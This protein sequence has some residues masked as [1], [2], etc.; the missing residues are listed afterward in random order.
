MDNHTLTVLE[1]NEVLTQLASCAQSEPG[2]DLALSQLPCSEDT[3]VL[4]EC[5]L[6]AEALKLIQDTPPDLCPVTDISALIERLRV[7]GTVLDPDGLMALLANQISVRNAKNALRRLETELPGL[8][9]IVA[10][11]TGFPKWEQWVGGSL[12]DKGDVLDTASPG[13]ESAR[14]AYRSA[15]EDVVDRMERFIKGK[16]VA[17]VIQEPYVTT[18]N[19]RHV[20]PAKTE[21]QRVFE[22]VVQDTSQSGQTL[23]VEPLFAVGLNN[24]LAEAENRVREEIHKILVAM[25]DEARIYRGPMA[26]NMKALALMDLVLAKAR[27]GMRLKGVLPELHPDTTDLRRARHPLLEIDD[28]IEC[29]PID[30]SIGGR[31]TTLVITGPNTGGKTVALKTLGLLTLMVQSGIP[32]PVSVDS[33]IRVFG[34]IYADIGDEQSLAQ[35]LSTFSGHM[36]IIAGLLESADEHTLVLLDELG[37]GTDPQEGSAIGIALIETLQERGSCVVAT[38]HHNLLKDFAYRAPYAEN[39]SVA[40]DVRT[41]KPAYSLRMGAAGRSHALQVAGRL[42]LDQKV[43]ARAKE[44]MGTGAARVDELLGRLGVEIDRKEAARQRVEEA[45]DRLEIAR[46]RQI[47]KQE[48]FREQVKDIGEKTRR[49][50]RALLRDIEKKGRDILKTLAQKDKE[51][52]RSLLR[53]GV[54]SM[55]SEIVGRMPPLRPK[56]GTGNVKSG[57]YVQILSI[58]VQGR[59][60]EVVAGGSEAEILSGRIRM[61][62]PVKDL[63]PIEVQRTDAAGILDAVP[64]VY[65]GE[66][67]GSTEI[68]LIGKK[69]PEALESVSRFLDRSMLG[70]AQTLRIVHG[71]GTGALRKAI[72]KVLQD[73]SRVSTF[74]PA[75]LNEGGD[76]V[77]VVELKE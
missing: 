11:M 72:G 27:L 21:Y 57:D 46:A 52:A 10:S 32:V 43:L 30:I 62:V 71:K 8:S 1:Y 69:V 23:F 15:R 74:G 59:I 61:R 25:S 60:E 44:I 68:N 9:A 40:F 73:D 54:A 39:A 14:R 50:A 58:G 12:S 49:D 48:R 13:L 19:G 38:T 20:V 2:K 18:R 24:K 76:G 45:A 31:A 42:G 77:T 26:D 41:L 75:P 36:K 37:A 7:E 64:V 6:T 34:R 63:S 3:K 66:G 28:R 56:R 5:D 33:R 16:T 53:E 35:S 55:E 4:Q 17:K 47:V 65:D 70:S 29:V 51:S 67:G 22:G